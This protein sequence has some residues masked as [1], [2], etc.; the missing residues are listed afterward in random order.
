MGDIDLIV[1]D[2]LMPGQ[3]GPEMIA[4]LAPTHGHVAVLYVT[5]YAGEAGGEAEFGGH[6]VLRK[7]FTINALERAIGEAMAAPRPGSTASMAAE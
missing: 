6:N 7:P 3:T 5:G 2:V 4:A 1:S